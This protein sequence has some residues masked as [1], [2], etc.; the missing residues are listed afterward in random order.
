[1]AGLPPDV[2]DVSSW[3]SAVSRSSTPRPESNTT[4]LPG[5]A[6]EVHLES[7]E[8]ESLSN[9]CCVSQTILLNIKNAI[10]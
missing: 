9:N 3:S 2:S 5:A 4:L 8:L 1:M 6:E 7:T 10:V